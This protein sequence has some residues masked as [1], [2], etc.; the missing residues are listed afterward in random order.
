MAEITLAA[1]VGRPLGSSHSR[2]LRALGKIPAVVYGHGT[3]P[4]PV[5]VS[6]R[7]LRV[8]LFGRVGIEHVA[9][10][11]GGGPDVPRP[12]R[13]MQRHPVKNTVIHVD[14][15]IV[16]RDEVIAADVPVSVIGEAIEVQHGD[17]LVDQQLF[18]LPVRARPADIPTAVEVDV[19]DLIIGGSIRVADLQLPAGVHT[20]LDDDVAVVVG[21]PPRVQAAEGEGV[22][23]EGA[24]EEGGAVPSTPIGE[25]TGS[26]A[27]AGD[28]G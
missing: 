17:G 12:R 26:A 20:E 27:G 3:E 22:E 1:E 11:G 10:A 13:E 23:G 6:A 18:T 8:A 16:R 9:L 4:V 5:A 24:P 28:E 2:R 25:E 19:T 21:Q 7:E 15:Q 14:F